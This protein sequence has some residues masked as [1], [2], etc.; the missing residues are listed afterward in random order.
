MRPATAG[1][2][3]STSTAKR[4][5][6]AR[7]WRSRLREPTSRPSKVSPPT[8]IFTRF[9]KEGVFNREVGE[10]FRRKVLA[11]GDTRE[12]MELYVDFM[13]R[14]PALEPLLERQGLA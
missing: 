11:P 6:R 7:C 14:E 4:S 1:P 8:E 2:A 13:G 10:Q 9:K 12:P 5:S 3:P